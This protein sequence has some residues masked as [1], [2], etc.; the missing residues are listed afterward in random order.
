MRVQIFIILL[1]SVAQ[2][3]NDRYQETDATRLVEKMTDKF[4]TIINPAADIAIHFERVTKDIGNI[5]KMAGPIGAV[6]SIVISQLLPPESPELRAVKKLHDTMEIRFEQVQRTLE[7]LRA[8]ANYD[9]LMRVYFKDVDFHISD[10]INLL[11]KTTINPKSTYGVDFIKKC[12]DDYENPWRMLRNIR[13]YAKSACSPNENPSKLFNQLTDHFNKLERKMNQRTKSQYLNFETAKKEA[14]FSLSTLSTNALSRKVETFIKETNQSLSVNQITFMLN[15]LVEEQNDNSPTCLLKAATIAEGYKREMIDI[16]LRELLMDVIQTATIGGFCA[17]ITY[18]Y[19]GN[20]YLDSLKRLEDESVEIL[21]YL[22]EYRKTVLDWF[23]PEGAKNVAKTYITSPTSFTDDMTVD[24][25]KIVD[26]LN[27]R[28]LPEW[29]YQLLVTPSYDYTTAF[30]VEG[31]GVDRVAIVRDYLSTHFVIVRVNAK[32]L[33]E[34]TYFAHKWF[35]SIDS[36]FL[37]SLLSTH[38]V[39]GIDQM[40]E[41]RANIE[42]RLGQSLTSRFGTAVLFRS[43]QED[44]RPPLPYSIACPHEGNYESCTIGVYVYHASLLRNNQ[45]TAIA[46]FI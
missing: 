1:S 29:T 23:W 28:G 13:G 31:T 38:D 24:A 40:S 43:W 8:Y 39:L 11:N 16:L 45:Q 10:F 44:G 5:I 20:L 15:G 14:I 35:V 22:L 30:T 12:K 2:A 21:M 9:E 33:I 18:E 37:Q 34:N 42:Q 6:L 19:D 41:I 36:S 46:F 27:T 26:D 25:Q 17:N 4:G 7:S 3:Q 32:L